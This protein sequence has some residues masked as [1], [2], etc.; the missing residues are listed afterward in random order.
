[1]QSF[2]PNTTMANQNNEA[3][4]VVHVPQEATLTI[5]GQPTQSRSDTRTFLS[6]E[7]QPGKVYTYTIHGEMNRD[8]RNLQTDRTVEVRAGQRSEVNLNFDDNK[9]REQQ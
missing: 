3:T 2:Y 4:I 8:G 9:G 6:P 1:M 5:D 7:L